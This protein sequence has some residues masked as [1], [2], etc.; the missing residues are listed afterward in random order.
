MTS[1]QYQRALRAAE[2]R[3]LRDWNRAEAA[4]Q[5]TS[6]AALVLR[7]QTF[8]QVKH[9]YENAVA[10]ARAAFFGGKI[11]DRIARLNKLD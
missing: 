1:K 11:A 4:Y 10:R 6:T 2:K 9:A 3:Y 5:K 8:K 7:E